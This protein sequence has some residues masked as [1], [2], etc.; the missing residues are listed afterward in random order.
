MISGATVV[1]RRKFSATN[2]WKEC[3]QYK[4]TAFTYVGEVCRY[5][6][7]QPVSPIDKAHSVRLCI[8]NGTRA[9]IHKQFTERF[10]V[11]VME[12]YGATEGNCVLVNNVAK[13]GAC[14]YL[15]RINGYLKFLPTYL[16]KV[17]ENIEPIR[18]SAGFCI[19]CA[20]NEKGLLVGVIDPKQT[21]QQFSGYANQ[22]EA[23][24]KKVIHNLFRTGQA[25]FNTGDVCMS[26]N[27]GFVY[28]CDRVGDTFRWRGENVSTVEVENI[29][30]SRLDFKEVVVYG[31]EINGQ[32]GK[33][34]MATIVSTQVDVDKLA[35]ELIKD[36]PAYARPL[37]L[38]L[39]ENVD[40][41]GSLKAQKNQLVKDSFNINLI[42]DKTF[43]FDAKLGTYVQLTPKAYDDIQNGNIRM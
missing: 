30:S 32:E 13:T 34:G 22:T 21:R 14:G 16:I 28:F 3:I 18:N 31:V 17:D 39:T 10:N 8:G 9:N 27:D 38:R 15:P 2:F 20:P 4:V 26:D 33:A 5:L 41:T 29:I 12:F 37:F 23:S 43:Y 25:G 1:L 6:V 35:N 24:Q 40:H 36:L 42:T 7:N 11:K 19:A